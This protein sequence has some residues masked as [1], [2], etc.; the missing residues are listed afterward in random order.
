MGGKI[1]I[2]ELKNHLKRKL[3]KFKRFKLKNWMLFVLLILLLFIDTT[4][5]RVNHIRMTELRDAVLTADENNDDAAIAENLVSLKEFV[6]SNTVINIVEE[7]G[8]QVVSFGT[9]P[10][11]LEHQYLRAAQVALEKAEAE[12]SSDANPNGNIYGLAGDTCKALALQNGWTWDNVNF[13]NCMV[14]E[15]N[16]YPAASE[17]Q[18]TIIAALPSTEL[19]RHNYASPVW[20]PSFLGWMMVLT[21][22]VAVVIF[23]KILIWIVL[24]LSLLFI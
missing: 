9:G 1:E 16:K 20:A 14:T 12:M 13:I 18:D 2:R 17:I 11:Y 7:N 8:G 21:L 6:F 19:Y 4:L 24:R 15:I 23:I 22:I 10:F 3:G 5:L